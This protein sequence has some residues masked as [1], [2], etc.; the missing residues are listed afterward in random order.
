GQSGSMSQIGFTLYMDMLDQ[1]VSALKQGKELSLDNMTAKQTEVELRVAALLPDD[2]I[3]DVSL[4]LSIYK[5]IASCGNKNELDDIQIELIDRFGLL[6][7]AAKN[8]VHIAKLRLKAQKIGISRIEVGPAG[9]SIEFSN[10]TK[11]D[12]MLIIGLIQQQPKIYK[13]AGAN[14]LQFKIIT[15]D[16][17]SRFILVTSMLNDLAQTKK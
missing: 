14:K 15:E 11:V 12:P 13:M 6:P 2:Y 4:R 17:K 1:A 8:L 5:R 3:F 7:Q 16:S 10:D 9:G